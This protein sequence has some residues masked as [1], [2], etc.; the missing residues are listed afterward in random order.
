MQF[1]EA[2]DGVEQAV[3]QAAVVRATRGRRNQIDVALAHRRTLFGESHGPGRALAF[4]K[5]VVALVGIA[6]AGKHRDHRV[7]TQGLAQVVA[8]AA[9][10]LPVLRFFVFLVDQRDA[11]AGHQHR[12]ATQQVHQLAHG[13]RR[14]IKVFGIGPHTHR[15]ALLAVTGLLGTRNQRLGHIAAREHQRGH[16]AFAVAGGF[17]PLGQRIRHA[18]AHAVQT[19]REAVGAARALVEL[20]AR[21]QAGKDEL[22][23][24]RFFFRMQAKRNTAAIVLD[25][26]RAIAMQRDLDLFAIARQRFV[27]RVVQHFLDDVQRVVG[28]GVHARP[29]FDRLQALE[30]PDRT[31]GVFALCCHGGDCSGNKQQ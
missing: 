3:A 7:R 8:Q 18:H 24:G 11:H 21:M 26:D 28:A 19:T 31:F 20:A 16:L 12:L 15:G 30:D 29:L 1:N 14:R 4:G 10:V 27:G 25:A 5:T 22:D 2:L 23:H 17:E 13:Q 6:L 9:L